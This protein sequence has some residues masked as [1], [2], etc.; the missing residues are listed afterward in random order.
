MFAQ[1]AY[2]CM[3]PNVFVP[4]WGEQKFDVNF[5]ITNADIGFIVGFGS[6]V[7]SFFLT[8]DRLLEEEGTGSSELELGF[9][10]W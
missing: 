1:A 8:R 5:V 6:A 7:E 2:Y 3:Q 10:N 9:R 4:D